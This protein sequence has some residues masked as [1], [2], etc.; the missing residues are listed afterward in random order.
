MGIG[1]FGASPEVDLDPGQEPPRA[2]GLL[3]QDLCDTWEGFID[4]DG[5]CAWNLGVLVYA[6]GLNDKVET[7]DGVVIHPANMLRYLQCALPRSFVLPGY[8]QAKAEA[9]RVE[10]RS[11]VGG[12]L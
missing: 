6:D 1:S 4:P 8:R 10:I 2:I 5:R 7:Q 12:L 3:A 9:L 11:I